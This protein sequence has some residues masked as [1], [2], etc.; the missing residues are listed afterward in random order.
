MKK[1]LLSFLL[2]LFCV[3]TSSAYDFEVDGIGYNISSLKDKTA[4]VSQLLSTG[5]II[6]P[7]TVVYNNYT[8]TVD[9]LGSLFDS[10]RTESITLS[11]RIKTV[12]GLILYG[13]GTA[14]FK[15]DPESPYMASVD[16]VLYS[17]DMKRLISYPMYKA[18]TEFTIPETVTSI[19]DYSFGANHFLLRLIFNDNIEE[20]PENFLY[21]MNYSGSLS[22]L[23]LSDKIK[24]IGNSIS[25]AT[26]L[27]ELVLPKDLQ[28]G[29]AVSISSSK[30]NTVTISNSNIANYSY[31]S[32]LTKT[33]LFSSSFNGI[34]NL[35]VKDSNPVALTDGIF[36]DGD[37]FTMKLY[38]PKG[39]KTKYQEASGW[40]K[41]FNIT[42]EDT[43][44]EE[45][46][47]ECQKP[48]IEFNNGNIVFYSTTPNAEYHYD[49][50]DTDC[51]VGGYTKDG[52]IHLAAVYKIKAYAT[53]DGY[54]QSQISEATLYWLDGRFDNPTGITPEKARRGIVVSAQSGTVTLSGL[55]DGERVGFY[56]IGGAYLGTATVVHGV[57]TCSFPSQQ[58]VIAKVGGT[59]IKV[60]L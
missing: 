2:I 42:E 7:E 46:E 32:Y 40:S 37:Y 53:S 60:K 20:L 4:Y 34:K 57:A 44:P 6:I 26:D 58:V 43:T 18:D 17:K 47:K 35:H 14:S 28:D 49:L 25:S 45:E 5:N 41:F 54:K 30:L 51:V 55:D 12:T 10:K 50:T 29:N 16:G 21:S 1:A 38:V 59:S 52:Y 13:S 23:K 15:V 3:L 33:Y 27:E 31:G 36:D 24:K 56:S 39:A 9:S 11:K 22:Y 48:S 8:F 19:D